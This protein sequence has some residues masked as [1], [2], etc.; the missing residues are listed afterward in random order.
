MTSRLSALI[1]GWLISAL[2][3][4]SPSTLFEL[5][6]N[7]S[8]LLLQSQKNSFQRFRQVPFMMP[9]HELV[10]N[11]LAALNLNNIIC[12]NDEHFS[13][14]SQTCQPVA[15]EPNNPVEQNIFSNSG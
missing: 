15:M 2:L 13:T 7:W 10:I 8:R 12:Y 11:E 6:P 1:A 5:L 14:E 9:P 3:L 4:Y